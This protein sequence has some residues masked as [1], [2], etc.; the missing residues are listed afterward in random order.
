SD[1]LKD[2]TNRFDAGTVPRFNV[3]RA[4]VAVANARPDLIRARNAYLI[5]ELQLAKILGLEASRS[6][7]IKPTFDVVGDLRVTERHANQKQAL[8]M[9]RERRA[10]LKAQRQNILTEEQQ[11]TVARAG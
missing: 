9:A 7:T 8:A 5:A 11:I 1:E 6:A 10:F 2:Q 3:L 4:E